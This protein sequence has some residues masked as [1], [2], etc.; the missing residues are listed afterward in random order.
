[1]KLANLFGAL[2]HSLVG[3]IKGRVRLVP[4]HGSGTQLLVR[5]SVVGCWYPTEGPDLR[6]RKL[7]FC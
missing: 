3:K 5:V 6:I 1:M 2:A 4:V 7:A